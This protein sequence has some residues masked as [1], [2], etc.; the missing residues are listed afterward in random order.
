MAARKTSKTQNTAVEE[1]RLKRKHY[2]SFRLNDLEHK[3]LMRY[4]SKYGITNRAKFLREAVMKAVLKKFDEDY[5]TLFDLPEPPAGKPD[6][7]P[8]VNGRQEPAR[9]LSLMDI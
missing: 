2:E 1:E 6:A 4:L 3:A 9:Q 7:N 5:P 8:A